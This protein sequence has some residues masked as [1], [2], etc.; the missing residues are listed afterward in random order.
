MN[1][2]LR[3]TVLW[4]AGLVYQG[5]FFTNNYQ[6]IVDM[7]TQTDDSFQ[8]NIAYER[9]KY[10]ISNVLQD[11]IMISSD[12]DRLKLWKNTGANLIELPHEP[13]DQLVGMMLFCKL[14]AIM[15]N[16]ILIND[17]EITST[18]GD[19]MVYLHSE[20][21]SVGPFASD[22]WWNDSRPKFSSPISGRKEKVVSIERSPD[23]K[24]I[25]LD[26]AQPEPPNDPVIF[27]K[28]RHDDQ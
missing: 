1:V 28:S 9:L 26:W 7:T 20:N 24:H 2:R 18:H 12:S 15:E 13:V 17:L 16:R 14:N 4:S 6:V 22:G 3:K 25:G 23:W 21:E 5:E 8:Q 27:V 19:E 11:S 10:T